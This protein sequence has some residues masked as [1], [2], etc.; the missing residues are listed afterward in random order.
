MVGNVDPS[1]L[2]GHDR[3][4]IQPDG[5]RPG[6]HHL[7]PLSSEVAQPPLGHLA[8]SGISRTEKEHS[9]FHHAASGRNHCLVRL[10]AAHTDNMTG[11]STKTPTTV[12]SAAPDSGPK[13]AIAVATANSKKLL[14]PMRAPGAATEYGTFHNFINP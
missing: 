11:T 9:L 3:I 1:L 10:Q 7:K 12:A 4:G 14:A 13:R 8:S 6:A 5:M 2:H